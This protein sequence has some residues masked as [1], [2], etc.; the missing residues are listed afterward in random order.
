MIRV[1]GIRPKDGDEL[2]VKS[3]VKAVT[4]LSDSENDC[5]GKITVAPSCMD[6][7]NLVA[8]VDFKVLPEFLSSLKKGSSQVCEVPGQNGYYLDFDALFV[9]FTQMYPTETTPTVE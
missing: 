7:D 1:S 5:V 2:R 3:L 6:T 9:G 4:G 8:I